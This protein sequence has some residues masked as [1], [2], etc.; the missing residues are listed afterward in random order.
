MP[1]DEVVLYQQILL[2]PSEAFHCL[3]FC[4]LQ[5]KKKNSDSFEVAVEDVTKYIYA[6]HKKKRKT[7]VA[8]PDEYRMNDDAESARP[9]TIDDPNVNLK[10][11]R[12]LQN[13]MM[14]MSATSKK[15]ESSIRIRVLLKV[16]MG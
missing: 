7:I 2:A 6:T 3:R 14:T 9:S 12:I 11:V 16:S 8:G 5:R 15:H 4:D 13:K 1:D 10:T